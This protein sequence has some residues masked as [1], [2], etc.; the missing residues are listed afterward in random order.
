M[1]GRKKV[2]LGFLVPI[3]SVPRLSLLVCASSCALQ[4]GWL[5][6]KRS[7]AGA[8]TARGIAAA[9]PVFCCKRSLH[10]SRQGALIA[11]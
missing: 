1:G 9:P 11:Y 5:F 4:P 7:Q 6:P 2:L 3:L 8:L 10:L